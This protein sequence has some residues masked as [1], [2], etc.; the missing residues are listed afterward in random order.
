VAFARIGWDK[1][2]SASPN[3]VEE[4]FV[5]IEQPLQIGSGSLPGVYKL[6]Q[7]CRQFCR[8]IAI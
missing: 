8:R 2:R 3:T 5:F 7:S 1:K 6:S 4:S